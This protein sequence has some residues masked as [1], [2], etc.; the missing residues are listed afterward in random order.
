MHK[1]LS[2]KNNKKFLSTEKNNLSTPVILYDTAGERVYQAEVFS[3]SFRR[4]NI[5]IS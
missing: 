2:E 4:F 1:I 3:N 5:S